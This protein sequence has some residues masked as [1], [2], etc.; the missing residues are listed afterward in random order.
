MATLQIQVY[1]GGVW[2]DCATLTLEHPD[3]GVGSRS[4][5]DYDFDYYASLAS[6][7]DQQGA[8]RDIRAVSVRHPVNMALHRSER[9]LPFVLDLI[10]Q[11]AMRRRFAAE[12]NWR[13]LRRSA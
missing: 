8:V 10:P 7:D 1:V 5:I 4:M 2:R 12:R 11:G 6:E 13:K 9:W 3:A